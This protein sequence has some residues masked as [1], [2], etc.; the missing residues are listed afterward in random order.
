VKRLR[1]SLAEGL[2]KSL[3]RKASITP[4]SQAKEKAESEEADPK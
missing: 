2:T 3:L 4:I 1:A